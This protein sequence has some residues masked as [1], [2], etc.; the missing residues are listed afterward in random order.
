MSRRR[1][2]PSSPVL[3]RSTLL[4]CLLLA[5][6]L[7]LPGVAAAQ[8]GTVSGTI[9]D[10]STHLPIASVTVDVVIVDGSTIA[11]ASTNAS[12][13]YTVSGLPPGALYYV[14][15]QSVAAGYIAAVYPDATCPGSCGAL[16]LAA[17]TPIQVPAGG[18]VSGRNFALA[19]GGRI[20][21]TVSAAGGGAPIAGA[22]VTAWARVGTSALATFSTVSDASGAYRIPGLPPGTYFL[23]TSNGAGFQD[24]IYDNVP[25][26]GF[27]QP[28]TAVSTGT[29]VP[30]V[31]GA[32]ASGRDFSLETGGR[33]TGIVT[34]AT[35]SAPVQ[36]VPVSAYVRVGAMTVLAGSAITNAVGEYAIQGLAPATYAVFTE[37]GI[38][39]NEIYDGILCPLSCSATT[40]VESGAGV[41][42][43][44]GTT[45][46]GV[47][48]ALDPGGNISGTVTNAAT[49]APAAGVPVIASVKVGSTLLTRETTTDAS[50]VYA[51]VGLPSGSYALH[52]SSASYVNRIYDGQYC[53]ASGRL[54]SSR[55]AWTN[56]S[57][58]SVT[59]GHTTSDRNFALDPNV[60]QGTIGGTITDAGSGLPI[61]GVGVEI[62]YVFITRVDTI[63]AMY[64]RTTTTVD[65]RYS[66]DIQVVGPFGYYVAT[67]GNHTYRNEIFD[68]MPCLGTSCEP[69]AI[70]RGTSIA[71]PNGGSRTADFGLSAGDRI[72][73]TVTDAATGAPLSDVTVELYQS[74]SGSFA[75]SARTNGAGRYVVTGI[76]NGTY[77]GFTSNSREYVS[78]IFDNIRCTTT[79]SSATAVVTG[80]PIVVTGAG[81]FGASD[82]AELVTGVDFGLD[83]RNEAPG[84]P[85]NLQALT[86]TFNVQL[87][88]MAPTPSATGVATSYIVEAGLSPGTTIVSIPVSTSSYLAVGVP[89]GAYYVR[90]RGVNAAGVGPPSNEVVLVVA[91]SGA[92]L[93][94]P[95][96]NA[97]AFLSGGLLTMTWAPATAGG[98]PTD[99]LVEAGTS[100]GA[101]NVGTLVVSGTAFTYTPVTPVPNGYYYLRV[102]A[103]NAVGVSAA[104]AESFVVV[105]GVLSPPEAPTLA[106][107]VVSG[108]AVTLTWMAGRSPLPVTSYIIEAGSAPGLA[109][110]ATMNTGTAAPSQSFSGVPPGIYYVRVR[111]V[112]AQ[113]VSVVSNERTVTVS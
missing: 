34:D 62:W 46:A 91:A 26:V 59:S 87:T 35:T 97:V 12:G 3:S 8:T 41:A 103:R 48:F 45:T 33:I 42:V 50:G 110:L 102:R 14:I 106:D 54:C 25:C 18:N 43:G 29:A 4:A 61:A 56:G 10:V 98:R 75:G 84:A 44:H 15:A 32:T 88:W 69:A 92:S 58:V 79:C 17:G 82:V 1:R 2:N 13:A 57:L 104:S 94:E 6:A 74:P 107:A 89:P 67:F 19:P 90:V 30:V 23:A 111:A 86:T 22:S 100:T 81:A 78:E 27:C 37:S 9:T 93:P 36:D 76:P 68:D 20:S 11:S 16:D 108:S 70:V 99:Y 71:P 31:A 52:T 80:T 96:T 77:V 47:N 60:S 95:P 63:Y 28:T 53:N 38:R 24:E 49:G 72:G 51:L 65:G 109:N 5:V 101:A 85:T 73:G 64:G 7:L 55:D 112:N 39:T 83:V 105:G 113:G 21:G 40:A 66:F